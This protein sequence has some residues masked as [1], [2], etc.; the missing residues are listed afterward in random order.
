MSFLVI[1]STQYYSAL[2]KYNWLLPDYTD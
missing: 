1:A 2:R